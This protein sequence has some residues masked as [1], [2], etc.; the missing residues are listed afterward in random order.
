MRAPSSLRPQDAARLWNFG[1]QEGTQLQPR[2]LEPVAV[3]GGGW[4]FVSPEALWQ[5]PE[6]LPRVEKASD[7]GSLLGPEVVAQCEGALL[8]RPCVLTA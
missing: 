6:G 4:I 7:L 2:L 3:R 1:E 8:V 5:R